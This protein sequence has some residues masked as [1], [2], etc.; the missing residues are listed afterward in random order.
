MA[1]QGENA[2]VLVTAANDQLGTLICGVATRRSR[3]CQ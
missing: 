2:A 3:H 1:D